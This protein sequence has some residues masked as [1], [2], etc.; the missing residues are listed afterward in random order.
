MTNG[1]RNLT[2][3]LMLISLGLSAA[4]WI[5]ACR[6][7]GQDDELSLADLTA[8]RAAL[9]GKA[10]ADDAR[11]SD[12]PARVGFRDLWERSDAHRGRRVTVQGRVERIFRQGPVG[13]FPP[14]IQVWVY[15]PAGDPFCLVFPSPTDPA[16][17]D[18]DPEHRDGRPPVEPRGRMPVATD[19]HPRPGSNGPFHGHVLEDGPLRGRGRAPAGPVDRGRPP[20]GAGTRRG[21]PDARHRRPSPA[22]HRLDPDFPRIG[23][24]APAPPIR[25][26]LVVGKL[27]AGP[28]ARGRRGRHPRLAAPREAPSS[29]AGRPCG[30]GASTPSRPTLRSISRTT[31]ESRV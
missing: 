23:G 20:A 8:Y 22:P 19:G 27:G 21:W 7:S 24:Q 13:S 12:P 16:T 3:V 25:L 30:T 18:P 11:P 14:L 5:V 15:S 6:G 31:Q 10:T 29:A 4:S 2:A 17:P 9:S 1:L 28:D 26:G